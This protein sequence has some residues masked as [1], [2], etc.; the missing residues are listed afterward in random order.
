[1]NV[2]TKVLTCLFILPMLIAPM[3]VM[4]NDAEVEIEYLLSSVGSSG[5]V[6]IRNGKSHNAEDAEDHLRMKYDNGRRYATTSEKFIERLASKSSL[7]RRA[8]YID[9]ED[10]ERLNSGD[11]FKQRLSEYRANP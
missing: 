3:R 7:S 11:W 5:C 9:C 4:A 8:Y 6:F 1:M 2:T 10:E